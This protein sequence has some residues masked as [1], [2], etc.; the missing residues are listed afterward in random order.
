MDPSAALCTTY[1]SLRQE[2][3]KTNIFDQWYFST[4]ETVFGKKFSKIQT[5]ES[6]KLPVK[7]CDTENYKILQ[8]LKDNFGN[9]RFNEA[10]N[11]TNPFEEIGRSIFLTSAAIKLA[12]TDAVHQITDEVFTFDRKHS[13]NKLTFCDVA[14]GPG[15]FTQYIQYRY[16]NAIGYGMTL[17]TEKL[18][19]D[20]NALD[21]KRFTTFYGPDGT[22]NLYTNWENF[23]N[24]VLKKQPSGV[25]LVMGDGGIDFDDATDPI[26]LK[27]Q[28]F[29]SSRLLL[30]QILVGIACTKIGGNFVLKVFDTVKEVSA[31]MIFLLSQ[32]FE[33]T[34]IFKPVSS[35]PA[36]AERYI[37]CKNKKEDTS[38]YYQLLSEASKHYSDTEYL[39]EL[40]LSELPEDFTVWL[41]TLN[42]ISIDRQINA[43]K[44][45]QRYFTDV[46]TNIP[47]YDLS[48]FLIIWNLPDNLLK[49][50]AINIR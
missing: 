9:P 31:Q 41:T 38:L 1:D 28:E 6:D 39:Y 45:I 18:D 47:V 19:W 21:M 33:K 36:N 22:G 5:S 29:I 23:V 49:R 8:K 35:R 13:E 37:I 25:D 7:Y 48:K 4:T 24:F 26:L 30:T 40:F 46:N 3:V 34:L 11:V 12:N 10:R 16:P 42:N 27:Q 2:P 50:S 32:C 14:A 17:K 44:L 43:A 20:T 15:S